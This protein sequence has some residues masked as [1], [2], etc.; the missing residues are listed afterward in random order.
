M[1]AADSLAALL[2][3]LAA[4]AGETAYFSELELADWP[5][6]AV[7][8]LKTAGL[9]TKG[10]PADLVTCSGCEEACTMAVEIASTSAGKLRAFVVCDKRDDVARVT[11]PSELQEQWICSPAR[12]ADSLARLLDTRRSADNAAGHWDLGVL[13]GTRGSAHVVLFIERELRLEVA[14]HVLVLSDVL[15]LGGQGLK[16]DRLQ[17]VRCVDSP[18]AAAGVAESAALRRERIR[19]RLAELKALKVRN[20]NQV[21]AEEEGLSIAR[22]KQ[23]LKPEKDEPAAASSWFDP[24]FS[25]QGASQKGAK[26]KR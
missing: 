22:I 7:V 13:K 17:I 6:A 19:K 11:V 5:V 24:F 3:R 8:M 9:L 23:L 4:S 26:T 20:F 15:E 16:L 1:N 2:D 21:L 10:P 12:L 14:G 25:L 18:V